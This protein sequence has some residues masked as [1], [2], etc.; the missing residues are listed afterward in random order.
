MLET[1]AVEFLRMLPIHSKHN[2]AVAIYLNQFATK[3]DK[4]FIKNDFEAFMAVAGEG[5]FEMTAQKTPASL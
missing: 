3:S 5:R 4:D 1:R 2:P